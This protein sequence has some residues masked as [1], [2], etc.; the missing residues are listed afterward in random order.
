MIYLIKDDNYRVYV[1]DHEDVAHVVHWVTKRCEYYHYFEET[2]LP[3]VHLVTVW[4]NEGSTV[5]DG[6]NVF[7][8]LFGRPYFMDS[9]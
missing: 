1:P 5:N 9:L 8:Q 6:E 3:C 4:I 7:H 2:L